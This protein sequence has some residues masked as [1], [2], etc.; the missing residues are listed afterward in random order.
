MPPKK[1]GDAPS[2]KTV[3]KKKEKVIEVSILLCYSIAY[4]SGASLLSIALCGVRGRV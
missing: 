2:K 1:K 3:E 4:I